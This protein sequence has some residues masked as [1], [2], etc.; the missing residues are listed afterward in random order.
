M[1]KSLRMFR[2]ESGVA[3]FYRR[4]FESTGVQQADPQSIRASDR[5]FDVVADQPVPYLFVSI[6]FAKKSFERCLPFV[7][8]ETAIRSPGRRTDQPPG[9]AVPDA[10]ARSVVFAF[11]TKRGWY[12]THGG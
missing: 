4:D 10:S 11:T 12:L 2:K 3:P 6:S 5:N 9:G 1:T 8:L 7:W